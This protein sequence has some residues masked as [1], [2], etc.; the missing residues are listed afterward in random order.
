MHLYGE[1]I[2]FTD[3]KKHEEIGP[4][5]KSVDFKYWTL[6]VRLFFTA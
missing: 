4:T 1:Q 3:K 2:P 6:T 5:S